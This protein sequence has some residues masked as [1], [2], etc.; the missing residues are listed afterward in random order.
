M[1]AGQDPVQVWQEAEP[2]GPYII[3]AIKAKDLYVKDLDYIVIN[4]DV[5]IINRT[6]GR[7]Q[8]RTRWQDNIHQVNTCCSGGHSPRKTDY[9]EP[10]ALENPLNSIFF[11]LL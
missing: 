9:F 5:T 11:T 6:T 10:C 7:V 8:P 4:G 2:W 3:N 1:V